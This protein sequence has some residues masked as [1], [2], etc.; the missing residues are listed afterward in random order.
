M[1]REYTLRLS[2][3]QPIQR[4]HSYPVVLSGHRLQCG[5]GRKGT[6]R[7]SMV[8]GRVVIVKVPTS[9]NVLHIRGKQLDDEVACKFSHESK[10]GPPVAQEIKLV[11]MYETDATRLEFFDN[12]LAWKVR[13]CGVELRLP[14]VVSRHIDDV[15]CVNPRQERGGQHLVGV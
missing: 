14:V 8:L 11:S 3:A 5:L 4:V 13:Q 6:Q 9:H 7:A 12:E 2:S 10:W 1:N 15:S